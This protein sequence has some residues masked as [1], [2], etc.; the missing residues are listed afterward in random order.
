MSSRFELNSETSSQLESSAIFQAPIEDYEASRLL[1]YSARCLDISARAHDRI[2]RPTRH[3]LEASFVHQKCVPIWIKTL[4]YRLS[5][6]TVA[7][8]SD[9]WRQA[10]C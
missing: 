9:H 3:Q 4:R 10:L 8:Y 5:R 2:L 6:P 7:S 1:P